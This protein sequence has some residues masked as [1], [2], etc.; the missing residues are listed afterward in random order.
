MFRRSRTHLQRSFT[1]RTR[2]S[3]R[4]FRDLLS[5]AETVSCRFLLQENTGAS[6]LYAGPSVCSARG[7]PGLFLLYPASQ[8]QRSLSIAQRVAWVPIQ[9]SW[10]CS[11]VSHKSDTTTSFCSW[12]VDR[13]LGT[14]T[15]RTWSGKHA[16]KIQKLCK[17]WVGSKLK[18]KNCC[19]TCS[20]MALKHLLRPHPDPSFY[21][22]KSIAIDVTCVFYG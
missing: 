14:I 6:V 18:C 19:Y 16:N 10:S 5:G 21:N 9:L 20:A 3:V 12:R 11:V 1:V 17:G 8:C 4:L 7:R 15:P 2:R 13:Q 22:P